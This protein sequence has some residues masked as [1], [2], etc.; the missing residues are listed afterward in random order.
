MRD[1]KYFVYMLA[2]KRNGTLYTGLTNDLV[3]RVWEHKEGYVKG[4]TSKYNVRTLVW[5][6]PHTDINS[7]IARE[8]RIKRWRRDWKRNL[9]EADNPDWLDLYEGLVAV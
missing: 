8:K 5:F 9:I 4:F 3:R 1:H 2:S 6:E 7:A